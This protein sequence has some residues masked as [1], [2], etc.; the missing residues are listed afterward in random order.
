MEPDTLKY[1]EKENPKVTRVPYWSPS[2]VIYCIVAQ[3]VQW[4]I[5][6]KKVSEPRLG[7]ERNSLYRI[8]GEN[9]TSQPAGRL[10]EQAAQAVALAKVA[11]MKR[12]VQLLP[13][14]ATREEL[15]SDA[16]FEAFSQPIKTIVLEA[17]DSFELRHV[18]N[19]LDEQG[20][21]SHVFND[22]GRLDYG[23]TEVVVATAIATEPVAPEEVAGI[24]DYLP[25]WSPQ[26][27]GGDRR[28]PR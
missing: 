17:R 13:P 14:D 15:T 7:I 20:V 11:M 16:L 23:N 6:S 8:E 10:I 9:S 2:K 26:V 28:K 18:K 1:G 21:Y 3:T 22:S 27:Y 12:W 25:E 19:L 4:P 5:G 24:L